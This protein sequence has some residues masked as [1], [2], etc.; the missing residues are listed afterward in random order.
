MSNRSEEEKMA[1][2]LQPLVGRAD[3]TGTYFYPTLAGVA[4]AVDFYPQPHTASSHGCAQLG[5][6][7]GVSVVENTPAVHFS[8]SDP[9]CLTGPSALS[10]TAL[11]LH[12]APGASAP[13][14]ATLPGAAAA[15]A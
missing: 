8:L 6:G 14:L 12:A 3:A 10:V 15:A 7:L 1:V 9:S 5:L 2:I 4:N 13:L 11:D